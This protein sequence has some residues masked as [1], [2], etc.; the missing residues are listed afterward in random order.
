MAENTSP[1]PFFSAVGRPSAV[2]TVAEGIS[3]D[4]MLECASSFLT[5]AV[6]LGMDGAGMHDSGRWALVYLAEMAKALVDSAALE[7]NRETKARRIV[8]GAMKGGAQ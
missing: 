3:I 6:D 1:L 8:S 2:F 4:T 7:M 5:S